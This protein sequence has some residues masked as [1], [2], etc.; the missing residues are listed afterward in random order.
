M[1]EV[2]KSRDAR[3]RRRILDQGSDRLAFITGQIQTLPPTLPDSA[4]SS[5]LSLHPNTTLSPSVHQSDS[6]SHNPQPYSDHHAPITAIQTPPK[7]QPQRDILTVPTSEIQPQQV[8][9]QPPPPTPPPSAEEPKRFVTPTDITRAINSSRGTRFCCSIVVAL[10]VLLSFLGTNVFNTVI[11]FG[12]LYVVLVTNITVV[13]ARLFF[14]VRRDSGRT[15]RS[16]S[17]GDGGD[18]YSQLAK[19]MELC[20]VAQNVADAVFMDCAVYS[21]VLICGL[22]VIKE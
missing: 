5:P 4:A 8:Q 10:L 19:M 13:I 2:A 7:D 18:E 11:S 1:G 9:L 6:I 17:S 15:R 20:L 3:R 21:I 12:P 14:G 22:S 16:G